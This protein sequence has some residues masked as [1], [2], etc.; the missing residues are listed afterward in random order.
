MGATA[1]EHVGLY[2][3]TAL[4]NGNYVVISSN[5]DNGAIANVGAVTWGNGATGITGNVSIA[6]SLIGTTAE[7]KIGSIIVP[8]ANGHYVVASLKWDNGVATDAGA[9]TWG[10]GNTG[11]KGI[12]S[13]SNSLVGSLMNDWIGFDG[14]TAL[15]NGNYVIIF[16]NSKIHQHYISIF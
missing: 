13:T 7:D 11:V 8:L 15:T 4:S 16:S 10:N 3:V 5:W 6:N 1:D 12:V 14:I 2:G 9:V